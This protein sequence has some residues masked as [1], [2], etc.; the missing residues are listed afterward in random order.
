MPSPSWKPRSNTVMCGASAGQHRRR[1]PT[2]S[3]AAASLIPATSTAPIDD[4]GPR[5]LATVSSH[6]S[7]GSLRQVIP[8]PT[9]SVSRSPSA[10][11]VRM[12]IDEPIAPVRPEPRQRPAVR[13]ATDRLQ[14]LDRP[15]SRGSSARR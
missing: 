10:T 6:S 7:S 11:N 5:A 3:A 2:R 14:R 8:P 1:S 15:P 12:R 9:W 13:A 4:S